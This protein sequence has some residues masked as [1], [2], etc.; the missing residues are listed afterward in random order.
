[1]SSIFK[2]KTKIYAQLWHCGR[3]SHIDYTNGFD[4]ISST[5]SPAKG[6]NRQNN[7]PPRFPKDRM[8]L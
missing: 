2:Y 1:M 4:L 8:D 7:K 6:I 3:I 5:S